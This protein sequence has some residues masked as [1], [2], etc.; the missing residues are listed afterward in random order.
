[1]IL[2]QV[3]PHGI[4]CGTDV[5]LFYESR[6]LDTA[7]FIL[8]STSGQI[9]DFP[10][11]CSCILSSL[12]Y[13]PTLFIGS[14]TQFQCVGK[15]ILSYANKQ[16]F[17]HQMGVLQFQLN[18]RCCPSRDSIEPCRLKAQSYKTVPINFRC[19]SQAQL[20]PVLLNNQLQIGG[21]MTPSLNLRCPSQL[22]IVACNQLAIN[23]SSHNRLRLY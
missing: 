1:M 19:Q 3:F 8:F 23:Q 9:S 13:L 10:H 12:K 5:P 16:S 15:E 4:F 17:G 20:S 21:P 22:Q 18:Q 11:R 14:W 6:V 7:R 2:K